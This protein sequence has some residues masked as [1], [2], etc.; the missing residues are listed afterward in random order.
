MSRAA[1]PSRSPWPTVPGPVPAIL[2][3]IGGV[4]LADHLTEAATDWGARL[5]VSQ[6][7]FL[8]AVFGGNDDEVLIGRTGEEAWWRIVQDRLRVDRTL[9]TEIRAD[10]ARRETW[11]DAL[12]TCLR[13]LRDSTKTAIVSNAWPRMRTAL[14]QAGLSDLVNEVVLS[15]EIGHAKPDPRIYRAALDLIDADPAH[16]LFIDDTPGHV[17]TACSLG[18]TGHVHTKTVDTVGRIDDF[19]RTPD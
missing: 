12:V 3:D 15:C 14:A 13:G 5:G 7:A 2:I 8:T 19:V 4:L 17:A 9:I 18:M 1:E 10:L 6:S 11:N 16:T